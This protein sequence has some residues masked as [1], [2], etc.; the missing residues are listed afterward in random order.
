[1]GGV[2]CGQLKRTLKFVIKKIIGKSQS[3]I[4]LCTEFVSI[5]F[6]LGLDPALPLISDNI[7]LK[8]KSAER[9]HVIQTNAG[10]YGDIGAVGD[11]NICVNNGNMQPFCRDSL[12]DSDH[13]TI[14]DR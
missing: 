12:S 2:I 5:F 4:V 1:M 8:R 3:F 11:L 10:Y 13:S 6:W 7:R 9:V 14:C